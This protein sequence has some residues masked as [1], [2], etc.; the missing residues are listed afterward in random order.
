MDDLNRAVEAADEAVKI[1]P[2][3]HPDRAGYL[4]NFGN[5]LGRLFERT[6]AMD[7]LNRAVEA[8]DK[9]VKI[10]PSDHPG[11]MVWKGG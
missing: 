3:N 1:T 5:W 9:A 7:D 10:T 11:P 2:S 8:I 6:R 4:N